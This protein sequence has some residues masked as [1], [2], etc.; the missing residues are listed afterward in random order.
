MRGGLLLLALVAAAPARAATV[1]LAFP[2]HADPCSYDQ[3]E[4]ALRARLGDVDVRPGVHD[5]FAGEVLV[6]VDRDGDD[7]SL[8][9]RAAGEQELQRKLPRPGPDC[10]A[11]SETAALM[12]DR[13]LDDIRWSGVGGAVQRVPPPPKPP[14]WQLVLQV[15]GSGEQGL[16]PQ[17]GPGLTLDVGARK[18]RWQLEL[19]GSAGLVAGQIDL[20]CE[21]SICIAPGKNGTLAMQT[22]AAQIALGYGLPVGFGAVRFELAPGAEL[23]WVTTTQSPGGQ[24]FNV[25]TTF[26]ALPF[27]GARIG[28]ELPLW[29]RLFLAL[30]VEAR[31]HPW[32]ERFEVT[33]YTA[34]VTRVFDGDA[35]LALGYVFF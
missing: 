28:Y 6:R 16:L 2:S 15:G 34:E 33:G 4:A 31:Y 9:V 3:A 20:D 8:K 10:V 21:N 24:L 12:V 29:R 14:G 22:G 13:Y 25:G 18:G 19:S 1:W 26:S 5:L 35:S 7:W 17:V 32:Q 23:F 11:L 30:R 27:A